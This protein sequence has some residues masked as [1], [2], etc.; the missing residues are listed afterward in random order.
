MISEIASTTYG[1]WLVVFFIT[2]LDSLL[3]LNRGEFLFSVTSNYQADLKI[4]TTPF[5]LKGREVICSI[6]SFPFQF[7]FVADNARSKRM[8][9]AKLRALR[10]TSSTNF[11]LRLIALS[12]ALFIVSG[13]L[14]AAQYGTG[15]SILTI[16]PA[17]YLLTLAACAFLWIDRRRLRLTK[18]AALKISIEIVLCPILLVNVLKKISRSCVL[19]FNPDSVATFSKY[20]DK[21]RAVLAEHL[22]E[23]EE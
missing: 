8:S 18:S 7:F 11:E 13:P 12:A 14:L 1:F 22:I 16:F 17:L 15:R 9:P 2:F 5:T 4:S 3:F 20:S 21:T 6:A 19:R 23:F 10:R